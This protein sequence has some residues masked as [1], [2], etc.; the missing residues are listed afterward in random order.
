MLTSIFSDWSGLLSLSWRGPD[1]ALDPALPPA[2]QSDPHAVLRD[3][4][5]VYLR[6]SLNLM[7]WNKMSLLL[8]FVPIG[9]LLGATNSHKG[10]S[11][12]FSA[13][14]R[15]RRLPLSTGTRTLCTNAVC[16]TV[17]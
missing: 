8:V 15:A 7:L 6:R 9:L 5:C 14:V 17:C 2:A 3:G 13:T 4:V 12:G 16:M 10:T 1:S 11:I